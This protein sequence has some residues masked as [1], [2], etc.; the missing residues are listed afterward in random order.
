MTNSK[1]QT[2]LLTE[3]SSKLDTIIGFLVVRDIENDSNAIVEKLHKMG[4]SVRAIA[5]I[6]DI[7]ENAVKIRLTRLKKKS[8]NKSK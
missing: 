3:I 8:A 4:F 1:S 5:P 6:A 2:D 7:S